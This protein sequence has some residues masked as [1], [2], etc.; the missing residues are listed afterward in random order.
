M[1][2]AKAIRNLRQS[3]L[4]IDDICRF[5]DYPRHEVLKICRKAG[6]PVTDEEKIRS[7]QRQAEQFSHNEEWIK[8][9]IREKSNGCFEYVSG[10][11]N[12]DSRCIV[13]CTQC[14]RTEERAMSTFRGGHKV[15]CFPCQIKATEERKLKERMQRQIEDETARL[16]RAGRG[17]QLSFGFCACGEMLN[18]FDGNKGKQCRKCAVRAVRKTREI[19]R[20][21]KISKAMVNPDITIQKLFQRDNGICHICGGLCDWNDKEV[22]N[23]TIVCGNQYPSIDHVLPLA[24]GGLHS[25]DNVKLAHRICNSLKGDNYD[26]ETVEKQNSEGHDRCRNLSAV[27]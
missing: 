24:K 10:Y 3:G 20:R 6:M 15:T 7:K 5:I 19:K 13:R 17:K 11:V 22:R 1:N 27:I 25:W 21:H 12:M 2:K 18:R 23:D 16:V 9:Y 26:I 8:K 14:G 4:S